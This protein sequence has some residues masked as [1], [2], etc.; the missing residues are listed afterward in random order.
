M[1]DSESAAVLKDLRSREPLFHHRVFVHDAASFDSTTSP[2]FWE[3]GASGQT[4]SRD[5]VLSMLRE[6]WRVEAADTFALEGWTIPDE[7]VRPLGINVFLFTYR[8]EQGSLSTRR[9]TVWDR[10]SGEGQVI[11]HQG[12]VIAES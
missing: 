3:M 7:Q 12:T 9:A 4:Y 1:T 5:Y 8:L 10:S 2:D 11:Y 6:R